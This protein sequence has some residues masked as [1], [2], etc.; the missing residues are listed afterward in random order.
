M[1]D[2]FYATPARLK[3]LKSDRSEVAE[4]LD[5]TR[6]LALA[7]PAIGFSLTTEE[8]GW[9][10]VPK[11]ETA[12][13]RVSRI[14]GADFMANALAVSHVSEDIRIEGFTSLPTFARGSGTIH[15]SPGQ[16]SLWSCSG[17]HR[18]RRQD[19]CS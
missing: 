19:V 1:R 15:A 4:A 13:A 6:R 14:M 7:H 12:K 16:Q 8:R 18:R 17:G 11:G 5:V 2:L 9:L 10:D 3:F